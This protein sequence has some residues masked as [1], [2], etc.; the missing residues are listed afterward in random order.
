[1]T[2]ARERSV[3]WDLPLGVV[4]C[5]YGGML[6]VARKSQSFGIFKNILC[7]FNQDLAFDS[8][9]GCFVEV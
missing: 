4:C 5:K 9:I 3:S 8:C 1:M 7:F 6:Y 2:I